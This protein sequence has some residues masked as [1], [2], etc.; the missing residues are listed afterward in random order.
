MLSLFFK[1]ILIKEKFLL[2]CHTTMYVVTIYICYNTYNFMHSVLS[3]ILQNELQLLI[4]ENYAHTTTTKNRSSMRIYIFIFKIKF[5]HKLLIK[6]VFFIAL[7]T[8]CE[9][10]EGFLKSLCHVHDTFSK[11]EF[12]MIDSQGK[13]CCHMANASHFDD[14]N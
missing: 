9:Q 5:T 10:F 2:L 3:Y 14:I 4:I 1:K 7:N 11:T 8:N 13:L 6:D 12:A